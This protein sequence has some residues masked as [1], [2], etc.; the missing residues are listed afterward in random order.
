MADKK[1]TQVLAY[2]P[3]VQQVID[4]VLAPGGYA[5]REAA[6]KSGRSALTDRRGVGGGGG[7]NGPFAITLT[8]A[9]NVAV[10]AGFLNR[11]GDFKEVPAFEIAPQTGYICCQCEL[12]DVTSAGVTRKEWGEPQIVILEKPSA[13]AYPLGYCTVTEESNILLECYEVEMA[14][15]IA[16]RQCP[17]AGGSA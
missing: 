5:I 11:N 12:K 9:G 17:L 2:T 3:R 13:I 15:I 10:A 16:T 8:E 7:Y 1:E 6:R 4:T 14:F